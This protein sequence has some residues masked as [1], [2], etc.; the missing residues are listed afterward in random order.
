MITAYNLPSEAYAY[1]AR[2]L[3]DGTMILFKGARY[4][5][6]IVERLLADPSDAAKLCRRGTF[7]DA[8]RKQWGV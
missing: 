4:L 5:E 3:K 6:G 2:E 7:W 8:K 1:L